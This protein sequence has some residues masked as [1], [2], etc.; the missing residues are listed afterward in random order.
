MTDLADPIGSI[1]VINMDIQELQE[2]YIVRQFTGLK[3]KND[4]EIYEGDI[5][6]ISKFNGD[7]VYRMVINDIMQMPNEIYGSNVDWYEVI[8]NIYEDEELLK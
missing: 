5:V 7:S 2:N 8:G 3:D 4:Q 6:D 1:L